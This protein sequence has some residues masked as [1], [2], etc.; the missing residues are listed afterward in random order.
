MNR[1]SW[2]TI[3]SALLLINIFVHQRL[4][5]SPTVF[6]LTLES[7]TFMFVTSVKFKKTH[8]KKNKSS[9]YQERP[10]KEADKK[11]KGNSRAMNK[12]KWKVIG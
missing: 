3:F 6:L 11:F 4:D 1:I 8:L 12:S 2:N 10:N 7:F 9:S 5:K